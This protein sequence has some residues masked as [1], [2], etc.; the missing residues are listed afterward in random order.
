MSFMFSRLYSLTFQQLKP[1]VFP[2]VWYALGIFIKTKEISQQ[3]IKYITIKPTPIIDYILYNVKTQNTLL[4][5]IKCSD[6]V[7]SLINNDYRKYISI[8]VDGN[9]YIIESIENDN[10]E[11]Y[12]N[13]NVFLPKRFLS[14][15]LTIEK[16]NSQEDIDLSDILNRYIGSVDIEFIRFIISHVLKLDDVNNFKFEAI[17]PSIE[18]VVITTSQTS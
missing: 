14:A 15:L 9:Q 5:S 16:T 3:F 6:V 18:N 1:Y 7:N 4:Y 13:P 17:T 8:N 12:T 10:I 11:K 2:V